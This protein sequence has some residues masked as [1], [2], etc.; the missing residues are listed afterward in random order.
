MLSI[1]TSLELLSFGK[2]LKLQYL[3]NAS[4]WKVS[5]SIY[6]EVSKLFAKQH[7]LFTTQ[8]CLLT[9]YQTTKFQTSPNWNKLQT[10]F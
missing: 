8:S 3:Y 7:N 10:T 4:C 5:L 9:Y 1:S 2:E 6:F